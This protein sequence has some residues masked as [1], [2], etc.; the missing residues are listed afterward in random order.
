M[1]ERQRG[2]ALTSLWR[3]RVG[4]LIDNPIT[5]SEKDEPFCGGRG[6]GNTSEPSSGTLISVMSKHKANGPEAAVMSCYEWLTTV[7]TDVHILW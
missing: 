1:T 3:K 5:L 4:E 2:R 7:G 6:G